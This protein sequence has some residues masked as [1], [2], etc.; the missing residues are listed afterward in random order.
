MNNWFN[1]SASAMRPSLT[2]FGCLLWLIGISPVLVE[3]DAYR[4][5]S[6]ILV[7]IAL[8]YYMKE[9]LRP[10]TNWLGWLCM[11]WGAYVILRF[12]F[13][14]LVTPHHD[15][16]ASDWLYA[17]PFFFPILGVAFALYESEMEKIIASFFLISLAM[18]AVTVSIDAP[19]IVSGEAVRPLIMHNQIHG[20]VACGL[21]IV[22]STFWL[23]HYLTSP[24]GNPVFARI[25]YIVVPCIVLLCL[26]A[27][28]G[29]KSKGVW[30]ALGITL[31][32]L[33]FAALRY[34]NARA[35]V[36]IVGGAAALLIAGL[37][38]VRHNIDQ[39]AGP[40]TL[41]ALSM[42][43]NVVGSGDIS[44]TMTQAIASAATPTSMDERL[45]LWS[46]AWE[47]FSEA[48]VFGWG[49]QWL[50]RWHQARY[51][52][53]S[54]T[55]LHNGYLEIL[56]R[57]GL[58]GALIMT[59]I[60][61]SLARSVW[62]AK[63]VGIIP[64]AAMHT[65]LV[66]LFFFALTL[67]SNSNNRLAIGESLALISSAFAC[68]CSLRL[69]KN[70]AGTNGSASSEAIEPSITD[71]EHGHY[72]EQDPVTP[73]ERPLVVAYVI[74]LDRSVDRWRHV[75]DQAKELGIDIERV[76]GVDGSKI[77]VEEGLHHNH[78]KFVRGN[79][80]PMLPQE[81]G[82][83]LAHLS[84]LRTFLRS[85]AKCAVIMEDDVELQ[86]DLLERVEAILEAAPFAEAVK[87]LNHR[88][89]LHRPVA[90]TRRGDVI[91]K[92]AFGPQGSAACY[93]VTRRG[94]EKL[95]RSM[96]EIKFPFDVG[97]ERGWDTGIQIFTVR[98]NLLELSVR[99][100]ESQIAD[101]ARY[102]SIK[103]RG[104]KKIPT[105]I[106]RIAEL[107]RRARYSF[108]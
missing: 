52:G 38:A 63:R 25:A 90:R 16:G 3:S 106:F 24:S 49:N 1:V 4:Y 64:P 107:G 84:A 69:R 62:R 108:S 70:A 11:G 86:A 32:L 100:L 85:N 51:T 7:C 35:A 66:C 29:A 67:L 46:N 36:L 88:T 74:N 101:R 43:G 95:L 33:A 103:V 22:A 21:I 19:Q 14:Y 80:R 23:L 41:A 18:L 71:G 76:P 48:P 54:Y 61:A 65:Y 99:A 72:D 57:F 42:I 39:T 9:P 87:L 20:A 105:H 81:Y 93:L 97:L 58:F 82:C 89:V 34:V 28:Y 12:A 55:L 17:F 45:Q 13:I 92:C 37:Y 40:T 102:R 44:Q 47:V 68:W 27:I 83:Y 104:Y 31:P 53:V 94:A 5:A 79:G 56:V 26:I 98:R 10:R 2:I 8:V 96:E 78:E 73:T 59:A 30:L 91:G 60:L 50:E 15:I 75:S 6:L 77:S